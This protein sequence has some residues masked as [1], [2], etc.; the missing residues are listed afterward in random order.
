MPLMVMLATREE[1][2]SLL[3]IM[4]VLARLGESPI[5]SFFL[6]PHPTSVYPSLL[7]VLY[8]LLWVARQD[9]WNG[10]LLGEVG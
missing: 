2:R 10:M 8:L 1:Y 3:L 7:L 4:L 9:L 6:L 5:L